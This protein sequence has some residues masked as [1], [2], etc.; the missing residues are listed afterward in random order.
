MFDARIRTKNKARAQK[1]K[2]CADSMVSFLVFVANS[3]GLDDG[4]EVGDQTD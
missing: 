4:I 2:A 1:H 3:G